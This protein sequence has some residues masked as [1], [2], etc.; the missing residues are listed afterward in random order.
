M[1][2]N[3]SQ[4]RGEGQCR[5]AE[6]PQPSVDDQMHDKYQADSPDSMDWN[7]TTASMAPLQRVSSHSEDAAASDNLVGIDQQHE[8]LHQHLNL[9]PSVSPDAA[10]D[11]TGEVEGAHPRVEQDTEMSMPARKRSISFPDDLPSPSSQRLRRTRF[12]ERLE[13]P[14]QYSPP[15]ARHGVGTV[16][17]YAPPR[18]RRDR[19]DV[20]T[21]KG[22]D[23]EVTFQ[24]APATTPPP[25]PH[26]RHRE[27]YP[28]HVPS[29]G[30]YLCPEDSDAEDSEVEDNDD[31]VDDEASEESEDQPVHI[32]YMD[33]GWRPFLLYGFFETRLEFWTWV[34][35]LSRHVFQHPS[36]TTLFNTCFLE[37]APTWYRELKERHR[38]Q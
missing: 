3:L 21:V 32:K 1:E 11:G 9:S 13:T 7:I 5:A 4:V 19:D 10:F 31:D 26:P 2:A 35:S 34:P 23:V 27:L 18:P 30:G 14:P 28:T 12:E 15:R 22:N 20:G 33:I 25:A 36:T 37:H 6:N 38:G 29:G 16:E 17:E 24:Q 8:A